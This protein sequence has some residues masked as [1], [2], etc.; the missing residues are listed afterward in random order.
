MDFF[1]LSHRYFALGLLYHCNG[2][3]S[4]ALQVCSPKICPLSG[5][6]EESTPIK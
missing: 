2:Q 1:L 5:L 6:T 4:A 3:D